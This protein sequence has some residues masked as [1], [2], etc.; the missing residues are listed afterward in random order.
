MMVI[1]N[2]TGLRL[3]VQIAHI[4]TALSFLFRDPN[5]TFCKKIFNAIK[6]IKELFTFFTYLCFVNGNRKDSLKILYTVF[7]WMIRWLISSA[8]WL[9]INKPKSSSPHSLKTHFKLY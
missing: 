1:L 6:K 5:W 8:V 7:V 3:I 9:M 4:T 2:N